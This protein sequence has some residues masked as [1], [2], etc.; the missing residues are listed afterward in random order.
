MD[1]KKLQEIQRDHDVKFHRDVMSCDKSKQIEHCTFHLSKIAGLFST[2]CEKTH[3]G[4]TYDVDSLISDRI[5]DLLIFALKFANLWNVDLENSY[6]A[7]L[8]KVEAR[9]N[10]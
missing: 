2:Y 5:P 3:H 4:E 7:R 6:L 9:H 8:R 1:I 10:L